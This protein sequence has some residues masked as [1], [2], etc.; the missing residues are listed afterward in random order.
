[1][2]SV[3]QA[4]LLAA[5]LTVGGCSPGEP[6]NAPEKPFGPE[7]SVVGYCTPFDTRTVDHKGESLSYRFDWDDGHV[8]HWSSLLPPDSAVE[9]TH[10]W[11][12][13][14]TFEVRAQARSNKGRTSEWSAPNYFLVLAR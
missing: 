14:G 10:T 4:L 5:V 12:E 13:A 2:R 9:D 3:V 11:N 6:P 8:S 1:M 7:N